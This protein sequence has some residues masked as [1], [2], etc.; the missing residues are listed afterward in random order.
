MRKLPVYI[1][2][3]S[4]E[5]MIG[6]AFDDAQK[7]IELIISTLRRDPDL[8]ERAAVSIISFNNKAT[9]L[10]PM[11]EI[12]KCNVSD[13]LTHIQLSSSSALGA[14]FDL[15]ATRIQLEVVKRSKTMRGDRKPRIFLFTTG[16]HTDEWEVA[17]KRLCAMK[18]CPNMIYVFACGDE[19]NYE[20]LEKISKPVICINE[21][22][23]TTLLSNLDSLFIDDYEIITSYVSNDEW[24][25][26]ED[27]CDDVFID[28]L[29]PPPPNLVLIDPNSSLSKGRSDQD[30]E[31]ARNLA[32][33][34]TLHAVCVTKGKELL[35]RFEL[36]EESRLYTEADV[37]PLPGERHNTRSNSN[38][39]PVSSHLLHASIPPCPYCGNDWFICGK[40]GSFYC[41]PMKPNSTSICP[42]CGTK[43]FVSYNGAAIDVVAKD[44][45]GIAYGRTPYGGAIIDVR[46]SMG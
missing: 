13:L 10:M 2:I 6:K 21:I 7:G 33:N 18:P 32:H 46:T 4:S 14:A 42:C 45:C 16:E 3:D 12:S 15:L 38:V 11:T 24:F 28:V 23:K 19:V 9:V 44:S 29:P 37:Y 17:F 20:L 26:K 30:D 22:S 35:V 1:L 39:P 5:S 40:C 25:D 34:L 27:I 41:D 31:Q 8:L 43:G 36:D